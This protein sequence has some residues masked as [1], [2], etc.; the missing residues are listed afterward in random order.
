MKI[1]PVLAST[2]KNAI[3]AASRPKQRQANPQKRSSEILTVSPLDE[4]EKDEFPPEPDLP[5][6]GGD[7]TFPTP[8]G[9]GRRMGAASGPFLPPRPLP[10]PPI[11][12][13]NPQQFCH[14]FGRRP[15]PSTAA[16][17]NAPIPNTPDG[18]DFALFETALQQTE[19]RILKHEQSTS[20][21]IT[22]GRRPSLLIVTT[23]S[24][25][26]L[27]RTEENLKTW[28][29]DVRGDVTV[30]VPRGRLFGTAKRF[31]EDLLCE[32]EDHSEDAV[33]AEELTADLPS[34]P[35]PPTA[36]II[37]SAG[38]RMN[39]LDGGPTAAVGGSVGRRM[40]TLD[41]GPPGAAMWWK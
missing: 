9:S 11:E 37:G 21:S 25:D 13:N 8:T 18:D 38:R 29:R 4:E 6:I 1:N 40:N 16:D 34:L 3:T 19:R 7:A 26:Q 12:F 24:L 41:G 28:F 39:T 35:R 22:S 32:G 33:A 36:A 15:P 10:P 31:L 23:S 2:L 27:F 14:Q 20:S 5:T 30:V 17:Q